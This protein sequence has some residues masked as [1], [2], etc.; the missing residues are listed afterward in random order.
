MRY[1]PIFLDL[2]A[3]SCLVVGGGKVAERKVHL[4]LQAGG[5]VTVISPVLTSQLQVWEAERRI[6]VRLRPYEMGDLD[7]FALVFAATDDE[8]LQRRIAVE[9][10]EAGV[11]VNVVDRPALCSFIVPAL[12]SRGDLTVAISTSGA[13]PALARQIRQTLEQQFGEEYALVLQVLARVR[14]LVSNNTH[15]SEERQKLFSSL[16]ESPLLEYVRQRRMDQVD[17]LLQRMVG[18]QCTC[19]ALGVTF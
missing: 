15:S 17:A 16:V 19:A 4:L 9:A 2:Q 13:S 3:R 7:G 12:V 18:P 11:L 5:Q 14:E 8:A 6:V 1:Y 10:R